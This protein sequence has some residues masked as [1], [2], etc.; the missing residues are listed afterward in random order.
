LKIYSEAYD[1][2]NFVVCV[3]FALVFA[4]TFID[5]YLW[6]CKL[7]FFPLSCTYYRYKKDEKNFRLN[8]GIVQEMRDFFEY[9]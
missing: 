7:W 8:R 2:L 5:L 4:K 3:G 9:F 6:V 1:I